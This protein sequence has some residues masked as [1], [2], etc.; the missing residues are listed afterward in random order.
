MKA[1]EAN[2]KTIAAIV[3][4]GSKSYPKISTEYKKSILECDERIS[5][6][7]I[8]HIIAKINEAANIGRHSIDIEL[9]LLEIKKLELNGYC[10]RICGRM[11]GGSMVYG[12]KYFTVSW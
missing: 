7:S 5:T 1:S 2:S 9:D 8:E 6:T 11:C 10:V 3:K 4:A 12:Y